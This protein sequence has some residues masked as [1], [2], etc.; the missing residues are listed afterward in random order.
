[1]S[2]EER[3]SQTPSDDVKAKFREA[4]EK[5]NAKSSG[6]NA[7]NLDAESKAHGPHGKAGG[8]QQFRRKS[9]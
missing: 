9:G 2:S 5:K 1:M 6:P 8:P 3:S 4:L 7:A